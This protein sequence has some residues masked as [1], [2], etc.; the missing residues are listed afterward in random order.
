MYLNHL[1][2]LQKAGVISCF[3]ACD[4]R[5]ALCK[6]YHGDIGLLNK[7][8]NIIHVVDDKLVS[9]QHIDY[10]SSKIICRIGILKH[11]RHLIPRESLLLLYHTLIVLYEENVVR[12]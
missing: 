9:D 7:S 4:V 11:I 3:N 10:I 1:Q 2:N 5:N 12:P 8:W 6:M